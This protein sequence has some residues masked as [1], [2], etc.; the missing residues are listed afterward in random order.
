MHDLTVNDNESSKN[1]LA[2]D[3]YEEQDNA[4]QDCKLYSGINQDDDEEQD[5]RE[6]GSND[7]QAVDKEKNEILND[8]REA[9]WERIKHWDQLRFSALILI[10]LV[11]LN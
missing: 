2:V 5:K 7:G 4:N 8:L 1:G 11:Y 6:H 3:D 10:L 9:I